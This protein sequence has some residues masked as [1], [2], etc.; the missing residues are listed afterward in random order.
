MS[1]GAIRMPSPLELA[2]GSNNALTRARHDHGHAQVHVPRAVGHRHRDRSPE[3]RLGVRRAVAPHDLRPPPAAPARR[4][5]ARRHRD[6]RA[7]DAVDDRGRAAGCAARA[8]PD[9]R[10]LPAQEQGAALAV[11]RRADARARAVHARPRRATSTLQLDESPYAGLSSF[12]EAD[13]GKFFGRNREIAGDGD[14]DPR[15][16]VDGGRR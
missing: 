3:R 14:A 4:Q 5:P 16:A 6:A 7:A 10:S 13:A 12:Q 2:T 11:G 1:S 15:P 8:D 9:R